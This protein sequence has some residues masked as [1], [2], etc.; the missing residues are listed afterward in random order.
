MSGWKLGLR[1]LPP[2]L[3]AI[4]ILYTTAHFSQTAVPPALLTVGALG[5]FCV[6][7]ADHFAG[8]R[9][10]QGWPNSWRFWL[11]AGLCSSSI[12]LITLYSPALRPPMVIAYMMLAWS[13]VIPLR[14]G[15]PRLQD[16]PRLR[17]LAVCGGWT[18]I[19]LISRE[20]TLTAKTL[21]FLLA[22][23]AFLT[24]SVLL[25]DAAAHTSDQLAGRE[26][27]AGRQPISRIRLICTLS[28]I[29]SALLF[30]AVG[31][32]KAMWIPP[33]SLWIFFLTTPLQ[34]ASRMADGFLCLPLVLSLVQTAQNY[35][36]W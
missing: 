30:Q 19:P 3:I 10:P 21:G 24:P 28:L 23:G 4:G 16:L 14:T 27:W 12:L 6:Y 35:F 15:G 2:P 9:R 8:T 25:N 33:L 1:E 17:T 36:N 34:R 5:A 31:A 22:W 32:E 18:L 7:A 13:Y 11:A 26:T 29:G 20:V